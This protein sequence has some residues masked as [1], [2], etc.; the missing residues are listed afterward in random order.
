MLKSLGSLLVVI[1]QQELPVTLMSI[2][3]INKLFI[4]DLFSSELNINKN[5]KVNIKS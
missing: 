3:S 5:P 1:E 4:L 2:L